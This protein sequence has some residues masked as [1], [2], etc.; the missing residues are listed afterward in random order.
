MATPDELR[1]QIAEGRAA[2]RGAREG[3]A[4]GWDEHP[5]GDEWTRRETAEHT[6]NIDYV[7]AAWGERLRGAE[8]T[9]T[10]S[11]DLSLASAA[12]ALEAFAAS[13]AHSDAAWAEVTA[14]QLEGEIREGIGGEYGM[15]LVG[16]HLHDHAQ[17]ISAS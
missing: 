5:E 11:P 17:Q 14:E 6:I 12:E 1:A 2:F 7:F 15:S 8:P 10:E 3:A 4:E 16:T 13:S 9:Y